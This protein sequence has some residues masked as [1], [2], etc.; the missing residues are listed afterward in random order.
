M[1]LR[2]RDIPLYL[3]GVTCAAWVVLC[4]GGLVATAAA[5]PITGASG[6]DLARPALASLSGLLGS[7]LVLRHF[8][9]RQAAGTEAPGFEVLPPK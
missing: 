2:L 5:A 9:R 8:L 7:G 1:R 4:V 3:L 6:L